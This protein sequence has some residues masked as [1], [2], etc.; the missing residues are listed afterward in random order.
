M[1]TPRTAPGTR[2]RTPI[3]TIAAIS[4]LALTAFG[5]SA[6]AASAGSDERIDVR[7]GYVRFE[8]HGD[9]LTAGDIWADHRGVR[10]RLGWEDEDGRPRTATITDTSAGYERSR[11]LS[12]KEGTTVYLQLCYTRGGKDDGCT[13]VQKAEA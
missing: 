2:A 11:N 12:I 9:E 1:S 10:A 7:Y 4:A 5:L 6:S 13:R 8:A 3:A